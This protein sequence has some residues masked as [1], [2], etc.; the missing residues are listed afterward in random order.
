MSEESHQALI[1]TIGLNQEPTIEPSISVIQP[2]TV[3]NKRKGN[4]L[5][6]KGYCPNPGGRPKVALIREALAKEL[7]KGNAEKLAQELLIMAKATGRR[8]NVHP[9]IQ[10]SAIKEIAD[11]T[12]GKPVQSLQVTQTIDDSAANRLVDLAERLAALER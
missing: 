3:E 7:S 10:L 2:Q 4:P 6:Q 12:E 8:K 9:G 1:S 5:W 11:R